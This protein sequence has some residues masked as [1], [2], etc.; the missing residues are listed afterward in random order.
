MK[1]ILL[2]ALLIVL[3][4][5]CKK[6]EVK[7]P[8]GVLKKEELVPILAD[9]HIAQAAAVMNSASDSTRYSMAEMMKYIFKIHHT[10]QAQYDSSIAFY[11]QHPEIMSQIYDKVIAELSKKQGEVQSSSINK[12]PTYGR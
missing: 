11:T 5:E 10:T 8:D 12:P 1:K 4:A 9:V 7:I 6:T 3:F 2:C